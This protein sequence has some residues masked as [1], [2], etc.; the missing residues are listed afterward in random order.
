MTISEVS[1]SRLLDGLAFGI[2]R[3]ELE[4]PEGSRFSRDV[5]IH[6]GGVG[7]LVED[8][9]DFVFIKQFRVALGR[10][11]LEIPAGKRDVPGESPEE[12]ARRELVEELGVHVTRLEPLTIVAP[13]PGYTTE[14]IH[15]FWG[16]D[17]VSTQRCPVGAEERLAEV[18][19]MSQAETFRLVD[20][21]EI[22]DAKTLAALGAWRRRTEN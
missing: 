12:T 18:V 22:L 21:G 20:G 7:V 15:V 19:R 16:R 2:D 13:S 8:D 14:L 9:G 6:P 17:I 10:N 11:V 1:R 4:T 3:V 5:L